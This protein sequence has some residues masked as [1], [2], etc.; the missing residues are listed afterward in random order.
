MPEPRKLSPEMIRVAEEL[1]GMP[2]PE[3]DRKPVAEM[4]AKLMAE[5]AKMRA[6]DVGDAEPA[7]IYHPS[8]SALPK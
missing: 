3:A 1:A 8:S 6:R 2:L 5:Y 7:T 4:L